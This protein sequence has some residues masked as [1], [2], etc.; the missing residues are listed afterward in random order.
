MINTPLRYRPDPTSF[1]V[2]TELR[3]PRNPI[4]LALIGIL[5]VSRST[6]SARR[7]LVSSACP[8]RASLQAASRPNA[9]ELV[10][11]DLQDRTR[12]LY[13]ER[14]VVLPPRE[15]GSER[16]DSSGAAQLEAANHHWRGRHMCLQLARLALVRAGS[17]A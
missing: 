12:S 14:G 2:T 11:R 1:S 4:T 3:L 16:G 6:R 9:T 5:A 17:I 7:N 13:A 15:K 8:S 10:T